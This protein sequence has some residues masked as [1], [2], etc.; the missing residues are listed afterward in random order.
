MNEKYQIEHELDRQKDEYINS[1]ITVGNKGWK[2]KILSVLF[3]VLFCSF[4][5]FLGD[6]IMKSIVVDFYNDVF[7][8]VLYD[9]H[10]EEI[11]AGE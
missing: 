9:C 4:L 6:L 10:L 3:T 1:K 2:A 11:L 7:K 8:S 5:C